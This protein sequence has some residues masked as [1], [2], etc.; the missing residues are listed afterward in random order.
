MKIDLH[1]HWRPAALAEAMRAR[2][3]FP[4]IERNAAGIEVIKTRNTEEPV[5]DAFDDA[6]TRLAE[7]DRQGI[8]TAVLSVLGSFS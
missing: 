4:R 8:T 2:T 1:A 6:A 3:E 5:A 7:M